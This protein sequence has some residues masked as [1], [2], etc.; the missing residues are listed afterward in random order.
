MPEEKKTSEGSGIV[1]DSE[2]NFIPLS[3]SEIPMSLDT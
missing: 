1:E 2:G 3:E